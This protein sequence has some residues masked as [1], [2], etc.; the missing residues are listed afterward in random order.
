MLFMFLKNY[1]AIEGPVDNGELIDTDEQNLF[2]FRSTFFL[3]NSVFF[4]YWD[5]ASIFRGSLAF[6]YSN[7]CGK[8]VS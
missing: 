5:A 7:S 8:K 1:M 2:I 6:G 3:N 4:K